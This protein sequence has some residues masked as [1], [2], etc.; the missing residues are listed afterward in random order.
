MGWMEVGIAPGIYGRTEAESHSTDRTMHPSLRNVN[1]GSCTSSDFLP[2]LFHS[3][4]ARCT[5]E[6]CN[7][8]RASSSPGNWTAAPR[9]IHSL[10][11][12]VWSA[13]RRRRSRRSTCHFHFAICRRWTR[14]W[15]GEARR[16]TRRSSSAPSSFSPGSSSSTVAITPKTII[17]Y[18]RFIDFPHP[19]RLIIILRHS[20]CQVQECQTIRPTQ[21]NVA[22]REDGTEPPADRSFCWIQFQDVA[23][24][25]QW[26]SEPEMKCKEYSA[27]EKKG[28]GRRWLE[29]GRVAKSFQ[30]NFLR[31]SV[32]AVFQSYQI[33][34]NR[35]KSREFLSLGRR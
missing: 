22:P 26:K 23:E 18:V 16:R 34:T 32:E 27:E 3:S 13:T 4:R 15:V 31:I 24:V 21:K 30:I 12:L 28:K 29:D 10:A 5:I 11:T 35:E 2:F 17:N 8:F 6:E 25:L 14:W 1:G 19:G 7:V 33:A 20:N 9:T